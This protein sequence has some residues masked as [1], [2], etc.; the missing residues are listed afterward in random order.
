VENGLKLDQDDA[1]HGQPAFQRCNLPL[2]DMKMWQASNAKTIAAEIVV[3]KIRASGSK[4]FVF[5]LKLRTMP[6]LGV[7]KSS[8]EPSP[9]N[10]PQPCQLAFKLL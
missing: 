8:G 6:Q 10:H 3:K 5:W 1:L 2:E 4:A 9:S 7:G